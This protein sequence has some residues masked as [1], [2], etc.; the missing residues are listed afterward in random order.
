MNVTETW[1]FEFAATEPS[2]VF[3]LIEKGPLVAIEEKSR[4]TALGLDTI[5][6]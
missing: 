1:Q 3:A 5:T 6:V 4:A 2:Q